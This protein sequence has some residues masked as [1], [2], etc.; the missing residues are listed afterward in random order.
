MTK[1]AVGAML[2]GGTLGMSQAASAGLVFN[3]NGTSPWSATDATF[4]TVYTAYSNSSVEA[5]NYSFAATT[6][7]I[8]TGLSASWTATSDSTGFNVNVLAPA[9]Q[10]LESFVQTA[11]SFTVTGS[12]Q[13]TMTWSGS[14]SVGLSKYNGG[15]YNNPNNWSQ[16]FTAPG[17]AMDSYGLYSNSSPSGTLTTTFSAGTYYIFNQLANVQGASFSFA[18]PAPG[19]VA[20]LGVAGIVGARR[21]RA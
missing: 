20:L 3:L 1:C 11:R 12:Q 13:I 5:Y 18:V 2:F 8:R 15:I 9:T 10:G 14:S 4:N 6:A 19:A 17:W 21:R 7:T 16:P